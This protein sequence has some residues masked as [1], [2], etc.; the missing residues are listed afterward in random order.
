MRACRFSSVRSIAP[1]RTT[2]ERAGERLDDRLDRNL[3][4]VDAERLGETPR[5]AARPSDEYRD[6][7]DT[8]CTRSGPSA[9]TQSAAMSAESMPPE[10]ADHDVAEAVLR[11]RSRAGRARARA[12]SA[13]GRRAARRESGAPPGLLA[14]RRELD[15]RELD[16]GR[17]RGRAAAADVAEAPADRRDRVD[18]DDEQLFLEAGGAREHL[19]LV[20]E[21]D[22]VAVE[23]QLVLPADRV[24]ERESRSCRTRTPAASPRARGPCRRG[25]ATPRCSRSAVHPRARDP[26]PV[27]RAARRPRRSSG[28]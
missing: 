26:S 25:T 13:R 24:A 12:A 16:A 10:I 11:R 14:R 28:R 20:V 22:R 7:I 3:T 4:E 6:G 17:A 8:P 9:S 2:G 1:R 18:V 15:E 5:V 19:A 27:A 23:D 21:H